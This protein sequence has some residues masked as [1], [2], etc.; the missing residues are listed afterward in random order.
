[1]KTVRRY[2]ENSIC[3]LT[4]LFN[5][6]YRKKQNIVSCSFFKIEGGGYK[7]FSRYMN[8][9][10]ILDDYVK[11]YMKEFRVRLFIDKSIYEDQKIMNFINKL[12]IDLV[13]YDCPDF[14]KSINF[15]KGTFGTLLRFFPM[16]NFPN[17]DSKFVIISDI[18]LNENKDPKVLLPLSKLYENYKNYK[19]IM[20]KSNVTI[21]FDSDFYKSIHRYSFDS[22]YKGYIFGYIVADYMINFK[23][24]NYQ[25]IENFIKNVENLK[26]EPTF[27]REKQIIKDTKFIFGV[28]EYF[29]SLTLKKYL[30]DEKKP[31]LQKLRFIITGILYFLIVEKDIYEKEYKNFFRFVLKDYKNYPK[32]NVLESFKFLDNIF[33][34]RS[35]NKETIEL[36][37]QQESI[38]YRVYV[39]FLKIYNTKRVNYYS[40][41]FLDIILQDIFLG[42]PILN[43]DLLTDFKDNKIYINN[44]AKLKDNKIESL[45]KIKKEYNVKIPESKLQNLEY[46]Y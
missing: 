21:Y 46:Y 12:D 31:F 20:K 45:K 18:D 6:D 26:K 28:D 5:I 17:N 35:T 14:K 1:M 34:F 8:G 29:T 41:N 43:F 4:P 33:Y 9:L 22:I 30:I 23:K 36:N 3:N 32:N 19:V 15:H 42:F 7:N 11:K 44:R 10:V 16:F 24:M 40:K 37:D 39:Y 27:Y 25:I 2:L 13:L 38:F